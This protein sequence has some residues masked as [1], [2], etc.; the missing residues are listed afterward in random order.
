MGGI[1]ILWASAVPTL[2]ALPGVRL[3]VTDVGVLATAVPAA[4]MRGAV[5]VVVDTDDAALDPPGLELVVERARLRAAV[6]A[7]PSR[8]IEDLAAMELLA[9]SIST[10][11][12]GRLAAA[13]FSC[14][15]LR[16]AVGPVAGLADSFARSAMDPAALPSTERARIVALRASSPPTG[17]LRE[18]V[19]GL[20][21][22][23]RDAARAVQQAC[24]F[25]AEGEVHEPIDLVDAVRELVALVGTVVERDANLRLE[26]PE[27]RCF[28]VFSRAQ[29]AQ[30][31]ATLVSN[32]LH[33]IAERGTRGQVVI[34]VVSTPEAALLEIADDGVGMI[35]EVQ[36]RAFEAAFTT[37]PPSA[38]LGLTL[39]ER[40]V[41]A[42]GGELLLESE[43]GVG[44]KAQVFLPLAAPALPATGL[45]N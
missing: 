8:G 34:R 29:L 40:R 36:D 39:A 5:V 26:L 2:L 38:G 24:S 11:L 27:E 30:T 37:R 21:V 6:R 45:V 7:I 42:A 32:S 44:T 33:A 35:R 16:A 4:A 15:V 3:V 25:M 17:A 14:E 18:T 19:D 28:V 43:P 10:S 31:V 13:S 41:R 23:L 22:A 12:Q 1:T 9:A 20:T